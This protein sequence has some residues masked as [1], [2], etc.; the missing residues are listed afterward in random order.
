MNTSIRIIKR[1]SQ[2]PANTN[3]AKNVDRDNTRAIVTTVKSWV[4]EMRL[5]KLEPLRTFAIK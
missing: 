5:R 3:P 4:E 2:K 1:G